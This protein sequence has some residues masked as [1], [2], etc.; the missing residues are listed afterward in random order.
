MDFFANFAPWREA[1]FGLEIHANQGAKYSKVVPL[2]AVLPRSGA[3][4]PHAKAR[5]AQRVLRIRVHGAGCGT[6]PELARGA[7]R[8]G[9]ESAKSWLCIVKRN[10][11]GGCTL[12]STGI[13]GQRGW[14]GGEAVTSA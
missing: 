3:H 2:A 4:E 11:F 9:A 7:S 10:L 1:C 14:L 8:K 6:I 12:R 13:H 5:S